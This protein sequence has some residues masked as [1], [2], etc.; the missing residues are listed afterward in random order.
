MTTIF[1]IARIGCTQIDRGQAYTYWTRAI[2]RKLVTDEC[3]RFPILDNDCSCWADFPDTPYVDPVTDCATWYDPNRTESAKFF[4]LW[5]T[6][7]DGLDDPV[8]G[9]S[10]SPILSGGV[11]IGGSNIA[12]RVIT[13]KGII[14]AQ[15]GQGMAWGQQWFRRFLEES[16]RWQPWNAAECAGGSLFLRPWCPNVGGNDLD[17]IVELV[18]V[19]VADPPKFRPMTETGTSC[20]QHI[21]QW[22]ASIICGNPRAYWA[23]TNIMNAVTLLGG[24]VRASGESLGGCA[25]EFD[26]FASSDPCISITMPPMV[27][28][29]LPEYDPQGRP[30]CGEG[31]AN[32]DSG[33]E[34]VVV[35]DYGHPS[36]GP[37][38]KDYLRQPPLPVKY[39]WLGRPSCGTG[40]APYSDYPA[41][42]NVTGAQLASTVGNVTGATLPWSATQVARVEG[43]TPAQARES[44]MYFQS[45]TAS[46][47]AQMR[48]VVFRFFVRNDYGNPTTYLIGT[49]GPLQPVSG[50]T[51][52]GGYTI[53]GPSTAYIPTIPYGYL[54]DIEMSWQQIVPNGI[55]LITDYNIGAATLRKGPNHDINGIGVDVPCPPAIPSLNYPNDREPKTGCISQQVSL[56]T[57]WTNGDY[58]GELTNYVGDSQNGLH[59]IRSPDGEA[60]SGLVTP[61]GQAAFTLENFSE[62]STVFCPGTYVCWIRARII[63]SI[64]KGPGDTA[65]PWSMY[66]RDIYNNILG[67]KHQTLEDKEDGETIYL[68]KIPWWAIAQNFY[69][70]GNLAA[71]PGGTPGSIE[72]ASIEIEYVG[73]PSCID[74]GPNHG[75]DVPCAS[76]T[77]F[78]EPTS[79]RVRDASYTAP[80]A[81]PAHLVTTVNSGSSKL[82]N[83]RL[84]CWPNYAGR[85]G[86]SVSDNAWSYWYCQ[87]ACQVVEIADLEP[88]TTLVI[89]G[90]RRKIF[91]TR[92]GKTIDGSTFVKGKG[93]SAF[94]WGEI[95]GRVTFGAFAD[96]SNAGVYPAA[97]ATISVDAYPFEGL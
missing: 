66:I 59:A 61:N 17:G 45:R 11:S 96:Y 49:Q 90:R 23:G 14:L 78:T 12:G 74:C 55:Q 53:W 50:I 33:T 6:H 47:T 65:H 19:G 22:E 83:F 9:H 54:V 70:V 81:H 34:S 71:P 2:R 57:T 36:S 82:R 79:M 3:C 52:T 16:C 42:P 63:F 67:G 95:E 38:S 40:S 7:V 18:N 84:M 30:S 94:K 41:T 15:D 46:G 97:D 69:I 48:D 80:N 5:I 4:G 86:P 64:P 72:Y 73:G 28:D 32:F 1:P 25:P 44:S 31:S 62:M 21:L 76:D 29:V 56:P 85:N 91:A 68:I 35:D 77:C 43:L 88:G 27:T 13:L 26:S 93:Q 24:N 87:D 92:N 60:I 75:V 8:I 89:D 20:T 10:T 58:S 39:D 37:G 51:I